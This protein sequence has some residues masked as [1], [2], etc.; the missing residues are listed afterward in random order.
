[1]S[2]GGSVSWSARAKGAVAFRGKCPLALLLCSW[3][4]TGPAATLDTALLVTGI[5]LLATR[6]SLVDFPRFQSG[7][8][9][10]ALG[11]KV[12]GAGLVAV[13][14]ARRLASEPRA[15]AATG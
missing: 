9:A 14:L 4:E 1:M 10:L 7:L 6:Y 3:D 13:T 8:P 5:V 2:R 12:L 11:A 15:V